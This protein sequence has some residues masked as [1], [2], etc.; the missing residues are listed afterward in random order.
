MANEVWATRRVRV[1]LSAQR[2]CERGFPVRTCRLLRVPLLMLIFAG[3]HIEAIQN[4]LVTGQVLHKPD[5]VPFPGVKVTLLNPSIGFFQSRETTLLGN[6]TFQPV[7]PSP[8]YTLIAQVRGG[9]PYTRMFDVAI[10]DEKLVLPPIELEDAGTGLQ[11]L[12]KTATTP[13]SG[14][15]SVHLPKRPAS[16]TTGAVKQPSVRASTKPSTAPRPTPPEVAVKGASSKPPAPEPP[17]APEAEARP[18]QPPPVAPAPATERTGEPEA[19]KPTIASLPV[20]Q[21]RPPQEIVLP[22]VAIPA[23]PPGTTQAPVSVPGVGPTQP[24]VAV[25]GAGQ[26]TPPGLVT[27]PESTI[28][29]EFISTTLGGVIDSQAVHTLPLANRDF[30]D[31]ALLTPGAYPVEQGSVL[32][33]AS[34]VVNGTRAD[35]NNFLLDGT[36]NNDHTIN[37]SLPFQIVEAMQE[38]R[39]QASTSTAEF[40]RSGGAQINAVSRR[41]LSRFHAT[42]F[43]YYLNSAL[44]ANNFF[45]IYAGG[46]F[47]TKQ[48]FKQLLLRYSPFDKLDPAAQYPLT[49]SSSALNEYER[50]Q[51]LL[52]LNQFGGNVGGPLKQDKV[53]AFVNWEG[54]RLSNPR[55]V[56]E[57]YPYPSYRDQALC[58]SNELNPK[59]PRRGEPGPN[60][61]RVCDP[62]ALKLFSLYPAT[63][64]DPFPVPPGVGNNHEPY[65]NLFA[66]TSANSTDTDNFLG[67]VDWQVAKRDLMSFKHNIQW[68]DQIQGGSVPATPNYPGD[69]TDVNGQN[70]NF[71]YNYVHE[72][73]QASNEFRLGWNRFRLAAL[74]E[75]RTLD[76]SALGFQN[77][78]FSNQGLPTLHAI[79][80]FPDLGAD[81]SVPS[82]RAD[83]FWSAGDNFS[84]AHGRHNWQLGA[85]VG[86]TRL[87]VIN[88]AFGRGLIA[89]TDLCCSFLRKG[90]PGVESI[91]RISPQ[92]GGGFDRYFRSHSFGGFLQDQWR[93]RP[94]FTVNYGV[95]YEVAT[96]PV[97]L[98]NRLVSYYPNLGGL[99]EGGDTRILSPFLDPSGNIQVLGLAPRPAPR[100]GFDTDANNWAPRFG[101]AWNPRPSG[102]TVVRGGY[103]IAFDEQPLQPSVNM[104]LNPPYVQQ[105]MTEF[106]SANLTDAFSVCN[107]HF[108]NPACL[109]TSSYSGPTVSR[110]VRRPYSITAR[111]P[112]T[113]TAYVYQFHFGIQQQLG[114]ASLFEADYVGSLGHKLPRVRDLSGCTLEGT[115]V[116]QASPCFP[117]KV[118]PI[119]ILSNPLD[120][121]ILYQENSA[122]SSYHSLQVQLVTRGFHRLQLQAVYQFAKSI[123]DASSLQAPVFLL[124]PLFADNLVQKDNLNPLDLEDVNSVSPAL[125]LGPD[126]PII[127]TR[128]TLPQDSTNLRGERGRSDFD[129]RQRLVFDYI[130]DVPS[131][132]RARALGRGWQ[133]AGITTMQAGQPYSV[134]LDFFGIPLRPNVV[135]PVKIGNHAPSAVIDSANPLI[136]PT[137]CSQLK[138]G[139]CVGFPSDI[140]TLG[141]FNPAS[142]FRVNF[143]P[144]TGFPLPGNLGRNTFTGPSFINW[145]FS[146]LKNTNFGPRDTRTVQFRVEFFNLFNNV[147]FRQPFSLAGQVVQTKRSNT[148][149]SPYSSASPNL[150]V[151]SNPL[152]GQILQAGPARQI[153]FAVNFT[154]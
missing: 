112:H 95:R 77:L 25:S 98:R 71:S 72:F 12:A 37:Q 38:F 90:N 117:N 47:D 28:E 149:C 58:Q 16:T 51:S 14:Q 92:F 6:Y 113:R 70:Q 94:N 132:N 52:I 137:P 106:S 126:L 8:G 145:D 40:G 150:C 46:T 26:P 99:V 107:E 109:S 33:G 19:A 142:A 21:I 83:E 154:F 103:G 114:R 76:A 53:F 68:I 87:N 138:G 124:N 27:R 143:D 127:T 13:T 75:D 115:A 32:A 23:V 78:N 151:V 147:N 121:V 80:R 15:A 66:G 122:N 125:S 141:P 152:F 131:W 49:F 69:G 31:L 9:P 18:V 118:R 59:N 79:P 3:A 86:Y 120:Q 50:R 129:V 89:S 96:A 5:D 4:A 67:R 45:S 144:T 62:L 130:Y 88:A 119:D 36:D 30:I 41:G 48:R 57:F 116:T 123:D 100:A 20:Q 128:P 110:W 85:E 105:D 153:Q 24:T 29:P 2:L 84:Y 10:A 133:L 111:D 43:E 39:V 108:S 61:T 136:V 44:S 97:E 139:R 42:L 81:L 93:P 34:L 64:L 91:A 17:V 7:P 82:T 11:P 101:F 22:P 140:N 1:L 148:F 73:T 60:G 55:P 63:N 56:F 74:A 104:L 134:F 35:M 54:F 135:K 102:K 65:N 146:V